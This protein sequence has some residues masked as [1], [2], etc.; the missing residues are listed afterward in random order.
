[1]LMVAMLN[2][3][4]DAKAGHNS[5]RTATHRS[6]V[7]YYIGLWTG[8]T[9]MYYSSDLNADGGN[10]ENGDKDTKAVAEWLVML[11]AR[12]HVRHLSVATHGEQQY[13][14]WEIPMK[15]IGASAAY[16]EKKSC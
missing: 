6:F 5:D 15:W 11:G 16:E 7:H 8:G 4:K 3:K 2:G 12:S 10:V 13:L 14:T 1:M 9:E